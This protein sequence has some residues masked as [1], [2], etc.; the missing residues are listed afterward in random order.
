MPSI[1]PTLSRRQQTAGLDHHLWNNH[2]SW[3]IHA[4]EHRTDGTATRIRCNLRTR[5][6]TKARRLRD[7]ILTNHSPTT[8]Q[9]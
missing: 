6:V 2:G 4:T 7:R 9:S 1:A 5:D 3:W 8:I